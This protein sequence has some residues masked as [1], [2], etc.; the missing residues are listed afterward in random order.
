MKYFGINAVKFTDAAGQSVFVRY[1]FVP[2][3]GEHLTPEQRKAESASY[4]R[5]EILQR[6]GR[7][8][9]VFDWYA[10]IAEQGDVITDPR[11]L[12]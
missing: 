7:E 1:Q 5:D 3:A 10:Q 6:V 11:R 8:P 4:L 2:C 9:I 12:A